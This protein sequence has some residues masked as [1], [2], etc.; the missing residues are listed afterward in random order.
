[1]QGSVTNRLPSNAFWT[2]AAG[3]AVYVVFVAGVP[4]VRANWTHIQQQIQASGESFFYGMK[5]TYQTTVRFEKQVGALRKYTWETTFNPLAADGR[6]QY[7]ATI[8]SRVVFVSYLVP[9][10]L[11]CFVCASSSERLY[12]LEEQSL[13]SHTCT[14][15]LLFPHV[16]S[17]AGSGPLY[18]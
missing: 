10:C 14:A 7:L 6:N 13:F 16:G 5:N 18:E 17:W 1:M 2:D 11:V 3:I 8:F 4:L 9:P 15:F 12:L